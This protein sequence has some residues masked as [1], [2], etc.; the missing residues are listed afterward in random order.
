[1]TRDRW[2]KLMTALTLPPSED[3]YGALA[4]AYQESH[5]HYHTTEHIDDCL[6]KLDAIVDAA[7][8]PAQIELALW[9]HDAIYAPLK[10]DNEFQSAEWAKRFLASAG[11]SEAT[12]RAVHDLI[13][14]TRHQA[15]ASTTDEALLV[16]IDLS[17][18]GADEATYARF[19]TNVRKE[20]RWVP[21]F[22]FRKKRAEILQSFLDREPIYHNER[23]RIA[24]EATARRN[25][26]DA[27][28]TLRK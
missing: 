16:D 25:L 2:L 21:W 19:E 7:K 17:I 28:A 15:P 5:R 14:V 13:M 9:F 12:H 20:Y 11:A 24:Y 10:S 1:M 8:S 22:M 6:A 4:K 23:M 18:L 27:I 3:T 26:V